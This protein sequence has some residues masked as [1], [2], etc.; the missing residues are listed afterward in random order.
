MEIEIDGLGRQ[1]R[2]RVRLDAAVSDGDARFAALVEH[3]LGR[4]GVT[5]PQPGARRFGSDALKVDGSIFAMLQGGRLVVKLPRERVAALLDDGTGVPFD[6]G[7]G[8]PMK[9]WVKIVDADDATWRTL[10]EEALAFVRR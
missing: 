3:F 10:A 9:E 5:P 2:P 7:K 6:A 4:P 1:R 8:R